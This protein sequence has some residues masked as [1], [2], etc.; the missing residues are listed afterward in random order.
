MRRERVEENQENAG[1]RVCHGFGGKAELHYRNKRRLSGRS[2]LF[3]G[4]NFPSFYPKT[5]RKLISML[6]EKDDMG[7]LFDCCGKP[8]AELGLKRDEA[9]ITRRINDNLREAGAQRP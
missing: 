7:V 5:T 6:E 9:E 1:K 4:C 2:I 8:V 3:P